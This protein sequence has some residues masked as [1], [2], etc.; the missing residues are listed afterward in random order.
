MTLKSTSPLAGLLHKSPFKPIQEHM[1]TVFD[2][3]SLLQPLFEALY[4]KE[5]K[6]IQKIAEQIDELETAADK[7]KSTFRLNMPKTLFL[8]VDRRDLLKLLHDQDSLADNTEEISQILIS[9][10]MEVPE[11]IT[12]QLNILLVKTLGICT[13][14]QSIVEELDELVQV[15][16]RGIEHDKVIG[17]ID[18]L[19]KSEHD[20]DQILHT[21]RRSLF[22]VEDSLPPV[23]VMFWYK[24]IDLLGDMSDLAENMSDRL[25][26]FLSK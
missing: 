19:R 23:S 2:C 1:R 8:P 24:I 5:Y 4:A 14:A 26:L 12:D 16:F 15:G 7:Q 11:A 6:E 25:L 18:N 22:A 10:D 20:I 21:I 13:E 3:V 9:R 17:M